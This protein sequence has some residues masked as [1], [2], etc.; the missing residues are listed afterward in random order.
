MCNNRARSL[1]DSKASETS[2]SK[3]SPRS[4]A[5]SITIRLQRINTEDR[6]LND[7]PGRAKNG[8]LDFIGVYSFYGAYT[9]NVASQ[10]AAEFVGVLV[11]DVGFEPTT[12]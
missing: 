5:P 6:A 11:G 8:D 10:E 12:R 3:T 9:S 2:S 1:W 7:G 4:T